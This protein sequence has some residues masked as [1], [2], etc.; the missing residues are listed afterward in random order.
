MKLTLSRNAKLGF[1]IY[2]IFLAAYLGT[3]GSRLRRPSTDIHFSYQADM[4]LHGRLEL[5]HPAPNAN[6]W[7]EVEYLHLKDG[8]TVAGTYLRSNAYHFRTLE[9]K[10]ERI[11]NEQIANRWK[12]YYVSFPP[13]PTAIFLPF[14]AIFGL[15]FNDVLLTAILAAL[16]PML[17]FFVLRRLAARGDST[18]SEQ[19]DLW[20]VAMFGF[21]TVFFYSSVIGQ[22]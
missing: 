22:V 7:S 20:L 18:R 10:V 8:R 4:W 19:D 21:G 3:S 9:G 12:K 11:T 16:A 15:A 14:V 5:G 1:A 2:G 17:L 6:D 13:F